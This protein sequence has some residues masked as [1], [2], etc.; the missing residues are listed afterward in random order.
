MEIHE[1]GQNSSQDSERKKMT[2]FSQMMVN[3]SKK[4]LKFLN[5]LSPSENPQVKT[6]L[7]NSNYGHQIYLHFLLKKQKNGKTFWEKG[8]LM[9]KEGPKKTL[10]RTKKA[11]KVNSKSPKVK[12]KKKNRGKQ[13]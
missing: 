6:K 11:E 7:W 8:N 10:K 13:R 3:T 2:D 5:L 1:S 9:D 12:K 4:T